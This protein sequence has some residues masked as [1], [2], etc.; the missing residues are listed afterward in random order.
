[1]TFTKPRDLLVTAL[2]VGVLVSLVLRVSY[3]DLPP[4]PRFAGGTL[5]VLALVEA[6]FAGNLRARIAHRPGTR[7]VPPL[8]A[9]RAVA[10]AKASSLAGAVMVGAWG[11]LLV[12]V[13]PDL[14]LV[15]AA[16]EDLLTAIIG[17]VC[18]LAL[19]GAGLWLEYCCKTP[20]GGDES[21]D[22]GGAG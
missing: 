10:L 18:A 13:V 6:V 3:G 22:E 5:G 1:M 20:G 12:F 15:T 16:S 7:P 17:L 2:I 11:A 4:V 19:V 9:A 21:D 14:G 8:T